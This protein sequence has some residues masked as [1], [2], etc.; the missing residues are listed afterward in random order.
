MVEEF[1]NYGFPSKAV[2]I[3]GA[4]KIT[5]SLLLLSGFWI[6]SVTRPAA[7]GLA[8]IMLGAIG[9]HIRV[10]DRPKKAMPAMSVFALSTIAL[11]IG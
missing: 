1:T 9:M 7:A 8:L 6:D 4:V 10:G 11:I 5:L 3:I 2:Y